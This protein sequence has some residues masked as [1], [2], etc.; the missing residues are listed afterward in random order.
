[1]TVNGFHLVDW[2]VA[3]DAFI[4]ELASAGCITSPQKQHLSD[5]AHRRDRSVA[6]LEFLARGND[7]DFSKFVSI[8]S[9]RQPQLVP[10]LVTDG[11]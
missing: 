8:L 7:A 2:I 3:D 5:M 9:K 1:L 6:V 4:T 11:G 10:L